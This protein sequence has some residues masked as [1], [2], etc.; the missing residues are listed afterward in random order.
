MRQSL[1]AS[2]V[3]WCRAHQAG[4]TASPAPI[5]IS[6]RRSNVIPLMPD[7]GAPYPAQAPHPDRPLLKDFTDLC[8]LEGEGLF[9]PET[10]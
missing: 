7:F 5:P 10:A 4:R 6:F 9:R 3:T 8:A 2:F 1:L